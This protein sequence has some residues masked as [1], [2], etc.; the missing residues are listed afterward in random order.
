MSPSQVPGRARGTGGPPSMWYLAVTR[1]LVLLCPRG[2]VRA[3]GSACLRLTR[4]EL[5]ARARSPVAS[6]FPVLG[7]LSRPLTSEIQ[8][9]DRSPA[10][11]RPRHHE[12]LSSRS[13]GVPRRVPFLLSRSQARVFSSPAPQRTA[14]P[15]PPRSPPGPIHPLT[16]RGQGSKA[17]KGWEA[18]SGNSP[19]QQ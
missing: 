13:P 11:H 8:S 5:F 4:P 2:V 19:F 10:P 14:P 9:G 17:K 3:D 6:R 12:P 18:T 15:A 16:F 7:G 1:A